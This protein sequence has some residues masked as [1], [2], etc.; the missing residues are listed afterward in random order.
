MCLDLNHCFVVTRH[1]K[2]SEMPLVITTVTSE[3]AE[4]ETMSAPNHTKC[5]TPPNEKW[6][7]PE[8]T[9]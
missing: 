2:Q 5:L 8:R 9:I 7:S 1:L 3:K 4:R 6:C